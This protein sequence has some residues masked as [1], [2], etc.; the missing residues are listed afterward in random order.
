MSKVNG[1]LKHLRSG[2]A[3]YRLMLENDWAWML[4]DRL[5]WRVTLAPF[6]VRVQL[7]RRVT[8]APYKIASDSEALVGRLGQAP[9]L[10]SG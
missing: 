1:A 8:L 10:V 6:L 7:S 3:R 5:F 4:S 9:F 2:Q